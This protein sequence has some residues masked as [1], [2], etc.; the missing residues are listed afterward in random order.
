MTVEVDPVEAVIA[1][2]KADTALNTITGG[3]ID[4]RHHYGQGSGQWS[5]TAQALTVQPIGGLSNLDDYWQEIQLQARCYG[6]S[7]YQ[8]GQVYKKLVDFTRRERRT[9]TVTEGL[10]LINYV[11]PLAEARFILDEDARPEGGMPVY[12]VNLQAQVSEITV[13]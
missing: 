1:L 3:R 5:Q 4:Q 13:T 6:D 7:P 9:V 11:V 10:A 2:M 12:L 8:A